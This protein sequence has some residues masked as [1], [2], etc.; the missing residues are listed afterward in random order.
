MK[1]LFKIA[2]LSAL[3]MFMSCDVQRV[4]TPGSYASV[5]N[6]TAKP[7]YHGEK[8]SATY[9]SGDISLG[10]HS[11]PNGDAPEFDD[12]KTIVSV[13]AHRGITA[14]YFN[15]HYGLG[16]S[17]G[18]YKFKEGL[19]DNIT[20]GE[21]KDFY[22]VN[23]RAGLTFKLSS[24]K[25]DYRLIGFELSYHNEFGPYQDKLSE[26]E[27]IYGDSNVIVVVREE[28]FFTYNLN[29][30]IIYKIN[31]DNA[32][33]FGIFFGELLINNDNMRSE[34][35]SFGGTM[36][37]YRF[38]DYTLSFLTES[39]HRSISSVKFGITYRFK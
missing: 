4:Y 3:A 24:R 17:Y 1:T 13:N 25:F 26:L 15:A 34:S 36:T 11:Q 2:T 28:S 27:D 21:T 7:E 38:K 14:K 39:G 20:A 10:K 6:Y 12:K 23:A 18:N 5:K 16:A 32:L 9:I 31:E 33:G 29:S 19:S 30:E 8:S 35:A 22:T 37:S